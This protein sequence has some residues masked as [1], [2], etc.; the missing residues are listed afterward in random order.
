MLRDSYYR[1]FLHCISWKVKTPAVTVGIKALSCLALTYNLRQNIC[2]LFH[3]LAQVL[4]TTSEMRLDFIMTKRNYE[5]SQELMNYLKLRKLGNYK[6]IS[7]MLRYDGRPPASRPYKSQ[8][9]TPLAKSRKSSSRYPFT[10]RRTPTPTP[11]TITPRYDLAK[12]NKGALWRCKYVGGIFVSSFQ[13]IICL[14]SK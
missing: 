1:G 6:K 11:P 4:F 10:P 2:R 14:P 8:I 3:V 5:L 7:E 13:C 12:P 9:L